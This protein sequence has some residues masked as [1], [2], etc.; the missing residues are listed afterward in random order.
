MTGDDGQASFH[1]QRG[2]NPPPSRSPQW[3]S[4]KESIHQ[5]RTLRFDPWAGKIPWSRNGNPPQYSCLGNPMNRGA[6]RATV[7]GVES[8]SHNLATKHQPA[9]HTLSFHLFHH[10]SSFGRKPPLSNFTSKE[11][12]VL[13]NLIT[14]G[15]ILRFRLRFKFNPVWKVQALLERCLGGGNEGQGEEEGSGWSRQVW[16]GKPG[17]LKSSSS[18]FGPSSP[19]GR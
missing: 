7:H 19:G 15:E 9:H 13:V 6:W 17:Q 16:W 3:L 8:V 10:H 12:E 14:G 5:F 18:I 4:G 11:S 2:T 1:G